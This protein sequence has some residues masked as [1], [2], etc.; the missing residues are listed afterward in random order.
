VTVT[1]GLAAGIAQSI[2][3]GAGN[4]VIDYSSTTA[5]VNHTLI[6]GAGDDLI[7]INAATLTNADTVQGGTGTDTLE[8]TGNT[9]LTIVMPAGDTG[10]EAITLSGRTSGAA[11]ITTDDATIAD[12]ITLVVTTSGGNL[13]FTAAAETGTGKV[14]VT[15]AAG[16]DNITG[17]LNADTLTG[18]DGSDT[19]VG[20]AGNDSLRGGIGNNVYDGGSGSDT[21]TLGTG[22]DTIHL[23]AGSAFGAT[24]TTLPTTVHLDTVTGWGQSTDFIRL[25]IGNL[26]STGTAAITFSNGNGDDIAA[27]A[28]GAGTVS[29]VALNGA[30][31]AATST[32]SVIKL[33]SLTATS[34][35]SAIGSGSVTIA[36]FTNN[37]NLAANSGA[38]EAL[39]VLWYDSVN[40]RAVVSAFVPGNAD[41]TLDASDAANV[42]DLIYLTGISSTE[43]TAMGTANV[44][45]GG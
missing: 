34:F 35:A 9:A 24:G 12:G 13:T 33:S 44:G 3:G 31:N 25:S 4:D 42:L 5:T 6:G 1:P 26:A 17:T 32:S 38:A 10:F 15:G 23:T 45:F 41:S 16:D 28:F 7:K 20:G 30:L 18:G 21:I 11:S 39:V 8:I 29:S 14:S 37:V 40:G 22:G 19:L 2:T 43:F 36:N 27:T